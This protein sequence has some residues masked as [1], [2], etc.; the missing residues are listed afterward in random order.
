MSRWLV[1]SSRS[2]R[3]GSDTSA[4]PEQRAPAPSAGQLAH[5]AIRRQR[6]TRDDQLDLLLEPPAVALFE[7][8]L[9]LAELRKSCGRVRRRRRQPLPGGNA[10]TSAPSSPRP[11]ATSS[12]TVRLP[13]AG[14]S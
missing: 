4:L 5:P 13:A 14:T 6:E 1:G 7:L 10:T 9:Q 2:S 11:D 8:M 12:N 3:S